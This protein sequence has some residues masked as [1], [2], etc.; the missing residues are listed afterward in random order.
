METGSKP[1]SAENLSLYLPFHAPVCNEKS[2][3]A[4]R[5]LRT[6]RPLRV[7]RKPLDTDA[8]LEDHSPQVEYM[9][10]FN[11]LSFISAPINM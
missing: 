3:N 5:D 7:L 6:L 2:D 10:V 4:E 9:G 8:G 1:A 11:Q